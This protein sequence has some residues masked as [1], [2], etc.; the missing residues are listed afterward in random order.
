[1][2]IWNPEISVSEANPLIDSTRISRVFSA[3]Y[4]WF[5]DQRAACAALVRNDWFPAF[6][7]SSAGMAEN[8]KTLLLRALQSASNDDA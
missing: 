6:R 1:M 4:I 2:P 5:P 8:W 3:N 7:V